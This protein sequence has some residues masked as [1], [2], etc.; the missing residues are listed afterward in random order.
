MSIYRWSEA[1]ILV[2]LP[3]E[4]EK[5]DELQTVVTMLRSGSHCD[6]VVD[7][8]HVHVVGGAWLAR[9]LKIQRLANECGHKLTLCGVTPAM[10]SVFTI[11]RIDD[12]FEF[13]EDRFLALTGSQPVEYALNSHRPDLAAGAA[14]QKH[15]HHQTRRDFA[16]VH[17]MP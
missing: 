12:L 14:P 16:A 15:G 7:F 6:V 10:K 3:G 4:L 9:L 1:M 8:S 17:T 5:R 13:A 2:D 11:A